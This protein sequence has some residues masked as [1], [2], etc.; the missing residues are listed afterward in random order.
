MDFLLPF[1][2]FLVGVS[3]ALRTQSEAAPS[4]R[5][6]IGD[7][8]VKKTRPDSKSILCLCDFLWE[9]LVLKRAKQ[10]KMAAAYRF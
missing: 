1:G 8:V 6:R 10:K 3:F 4:R 7:E 2:H 5:P 9:Q